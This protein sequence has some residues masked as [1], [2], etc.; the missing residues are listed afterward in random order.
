[1]IYIVGTRLRLRRREEGAIG[2]GRLMGVLLGVLLVRGISGHGEIIS[3]RIVVEIAVAA[4]VG[5]WIWYQC[6]IWRIVE[7]LGLLAHTVMARVLKS[8]LDTTLTRSLVA[9]SKQKKLVAYRKSAGINA[10]SYRK[11]DEHAGR[12][13]KLA[14][15]SS[16][17]V[18]RGP[19]HW[20]LCDPPCYRH[21]FWALR[22]FVRGP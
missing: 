4:V 20:Q 21:S 22:P 11:L 9:C 1:M 2:G 13:S 18:A 15:P 17:A 14:E 19:W 10:G 12:Q 8:T 7:I 5:A 6:S 16:A 3:K